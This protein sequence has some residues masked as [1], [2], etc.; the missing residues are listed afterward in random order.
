M[1][2]NIQKGHARCQH[3]FADQP[4]LRLTVRLPVSGELAYFLSPGPFLVSLAN[5]SEKLYKW[6]H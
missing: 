3:P 1:G 2:G 6:I 4:V 5:P